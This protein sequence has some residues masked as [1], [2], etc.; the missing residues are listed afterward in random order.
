MI[1]LVI[2]ILI[3]ALVVLGVNFFMKLPQPE[4]VVISNLNTHPHLLNN[5]HQR[6]NNLRMNSLKK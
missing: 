3:V 6:M 2:L 4:H 1:E 5:L